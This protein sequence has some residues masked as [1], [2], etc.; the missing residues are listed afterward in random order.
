[1]TTPISTADL[2]LRAR[3]NM[4]AMVAAALDKG[5]TPAVICFGDAEEKARCGGGMRCP[6]DP[7][8]SE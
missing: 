2:L 7:V 5:V 6:R 1:M 4:L 3:E 8:C